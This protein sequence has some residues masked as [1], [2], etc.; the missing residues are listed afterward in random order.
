MSYFFLNFSKYL[1]VDPL[2]NGTWNS[3]LKKYYH[4]PFL[5]KPLFFVSETLSPESMKK[6]S[7]NASP[8][9]KFLQ[10]CDEFY[11]FFFWGWIWT[12]WQNFYNEFQA[13]LNCLNC[14]FRKHTHTHVPTCLL[15][16]TWI[17]THGA[18]FPV[19]IPLTSLPPSP[20]SPET[21]SQAKAPLSSKP[22]LM[23]LPCQ[24]PGFKSTFH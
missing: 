24:D 19:G 21:F 18:P 2:T 10:A 13:G 1:S 16:I 22:T 5:R 15:F 17:I 6:A 3:L 9:E 7:D 14:W 23:L 20:L 11:L 12:G 8:L 4:T